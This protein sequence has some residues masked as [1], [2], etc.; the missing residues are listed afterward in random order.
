MIKSQSIRKVV[1]IYLNRVLTE[2]QTIIELSK[3]W[4][5]TQESLFKRLLKEGGEISIK[6]VNIKITVQE[7]ILI[8]RGEK[9]GGI[10]V[11]PGSD[12]RF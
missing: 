9:D 7:K 6:G 10:I 4:S 8:S 12:T 11:A 2:K 3:E 1:N 5:P